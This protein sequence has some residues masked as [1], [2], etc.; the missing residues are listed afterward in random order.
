MDSRLI[1]FQIG[2]K[3]KRETIRIPR[4]IE[5]AHVPTIRDNIE[6]LISAKISGQPMPRAAAAWLGDLRGKLFDRLVE[7]GLAEPRAKF[8]DMKLGAFLDE[9]IVKRTDLKPFSRKNLRQTR[10]S[11]V[12]FFGEKAHLHVIG[13]TDA[14]EWNR[15]AKLKYSQATV[16]AFT[17]RAR[18][19][20]RHAVDAELL[21]RNPFDGIKA[22]KMSNPSRLQYVPSDVVLKVIDACPHHCWKVTFALARW[23]GLRTPSETSLLCWD[24]VDFAAGRMVVHSPKTA[25]QGKATRIVPII[26]QLRTHLEAAYA[27]RDRATDKV[28]WRIQRSNLSSGATKIIKRSK[29]KTW[30]RQFQNLRSSFETDMTVSHPLHVACAWAGNSE[31]VAIEHYLQVTEADFDKATGKGDAVALQK[32]LGVLKVEL[33]KTANSSRFKGL[34]DQSLPLVGVEP[35]FKNRANRQRFK[36]FLEA[37]ERCAARALHLIQAAGPHL[38]HLESS[39]RGLKQHARR[40]RRRDIGHLRSA[41]H[42]ARTGRRK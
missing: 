18:Q 41:L 30:P 29:V 7:V 27:A 22:G 4:E 33:S 14:I 37:R 36:R 5:S 3:A 34:S 2:R 31:A 11:L 16:A 23:G 32:S 21:T 8:R 13:K 28:I 1:Q 6:R 40:S 15:A 38:A 24:D 17:R 25:H 9:Y 19:M 35:L 20:F 42:A 39:I 26:P 12:G 10:D